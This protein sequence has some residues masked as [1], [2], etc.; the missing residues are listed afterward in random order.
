M[1]TVGQCYKNVHDQ[2]NN[3]EETTSYGNTNVFTQR[4]TKVTSTSK[5]IVAV[6][7]RALA[8]QERGID[9]GGVA[10]CRAV[11][12]VAVVGQI[13]AILQELV[14]HQSRVLPTQTST[15]KSTTFKGSI[16]VVAS[17]PSK[18]CNDTGPR[19]VS[20]AGGTDGA[21]DACPICWVGGGVVEVVKLVAVGWFCKAVVLAQT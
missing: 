16:V 8:T 6:V 12:T 4:R 13:N 2:T 14:A 1:T 19:D 21:F 7:G 3:T 5:T 10:L 15:G 11:A 9:V 20:N 18:F 17:G